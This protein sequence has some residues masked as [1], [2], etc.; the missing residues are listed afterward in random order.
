MSSEHAHII[1]RNKLNVVS[2]K[3]IISFE[4]GLLDQ[5]LMSAWIKRGPTKNDF[6][7]YE[8]F[9]RTRRVRQ[10][11]RLV[12]VLH[13]NQNSWHILACAV[14]VQKGRGKEFL[15]YR[16]L[17]TRYISLL[18]FFVYWLEISFFFQFMFN[19]LFICCVVVFT[20][21]A[22]SGIIR[23]K[24]KRKKWMSWSDRLGGSERS[25]L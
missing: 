9:K 15:F 1:K 24:L 10:L 12:S 6:T 19:S 17:R 16:L 25:A 18:P 8:E 13:L 2:F 11:M 14:G 22:T 4:L 20:K 21:L 5:L 7:F 23:M 3:F